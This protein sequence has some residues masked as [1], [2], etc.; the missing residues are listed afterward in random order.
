MIDCVPAAGVA[1][2]GVGGRTALQIECC[3]ILEVKLYGTGHIGVI[4]HDVPY[5]PGV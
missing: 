2:V 3:C 1:G 4:L 5:I